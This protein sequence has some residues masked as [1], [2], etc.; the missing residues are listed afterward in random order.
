VAVV[1]AFAKKHGTLPVAQAYLRHL[2]SPEG[3]EIAARNFYRPRNAQVAARHAAMFPKLGLFTV[4][5]V[6]GG[7]AN[8]QKAHFADGGTFDR[9]YG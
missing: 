1:D 2:Y 5:E 9:I 3:Q 6:F 7:W 8:A 4:G